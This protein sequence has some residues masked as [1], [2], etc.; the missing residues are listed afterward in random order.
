MNGVL[1]TT[2]GDIGGRWCVTEAERDRE[3]VGGV[4]RANEFARDSETRRGSGGRSTHPKRAVRIAVSESSGVSLEPG[5][6]T[7]PLSRAD[8]LSSV[9][10]GSTN[11]ETVARSELS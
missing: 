3:G 1:G 8:S 9:G 5:T 11:D 2:V 4:D 7:S 10:G 6:K